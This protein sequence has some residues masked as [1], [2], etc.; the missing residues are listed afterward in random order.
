MIKRIENRL[1]I[2]LC[3]LLGVITLPYCEKDPEAAN[4]GKVQLLS[5]GPTGANLGDT[6]MIIGNNLEKVT[7]VELTGANVDKANFKKQTKEEIHLIIPQ[8]TVR[9]KI[10][11]KTPDG[12]VVSITELDLGVTATVTSMTAQARPGENITLTGT[13]LNWVKR[14]T[15]ARDKLVT[16]FVSQSLTQIVVKVPDDAQTG[17]LVLFYSG[18]DSAYL[19]TKDTLKVTLPAVT[20]MA[21]NP[22]GHGADLTITGTNL[23][24]VKELLFNNVSTPVTTFVSQTATQ[25]VV[26]TPTTAMPGKLT[27]KVA[28]GLTV[29]TSTDLGI[30][31]PAVTNMTPNPIKHA[32][33]L[34]ITGTN[35][36]LVKELVFT[37]ASAVTTFVSQSATQIVVKVPAAAKTGKLNLKVASGVGV[38]TSQDVTLILPTTTNLSPN[39]IDPNTNLTIT[40]TNLDLVTGIS[41]VGITNPITTFVSQSATQIVVKVPFG[42]LKGKLGL[43]FVNCSYQAESGQTLDVIGLPPLADFAFPIYTDGVNSGYGDWSWAARDMAS[44]QIVR[45][46]TTS[47]KATYG[48]NSYEGI[49]FHNDNGPADLSAYTKLEFSIFGTAGTG[50]KIMNVVINEQWGAPV[51]VTIVEGGWTTYSINISAL[52]NPSPLKDVILQ[53]AGWTGVVH[54]DHVG[55][56]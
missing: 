52:P 23:D 53:S 48:G 46:G 4:D 26:K 33:D 12:D 24:L 6:L 3:L 1:L 47:I 45:Q 54:I 15:F 19:P 9:G 55:L 43:S 36:N 13:N 20:N 29:T 17:P 5:F 34:T 44:T 38:S 25:I 28:S 41:F 35:L 11:L 50:G 21:P 14:I 42:S 22:V 8:S 31:L 49:R 27:L 30:I 51:T 56:R 2:L 40:G 32:Q 10:T 18:T 37:N 7:A 16:T 39:P